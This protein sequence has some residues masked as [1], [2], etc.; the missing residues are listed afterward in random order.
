MAAPDRDKLHPN[1]P[2]RPAAHRARLRGRPFGL[3]DKNHLVPGPPTV[4]ALAPKAAQLSLHLAYPP[5][6]PAHCLPPP[7]EPRRNLAHHQ[8]QALDPF[9]QVGRLHELQGR[10]EQP[11]R[12]GYPG[13]GRGLGVPGDGCQDVQGRLS[14]KERLGRKLPEPFVPKPPGGRFHFGAGQPLSYGPGGDLELFGNLFRGEPFQGQ[15]K[16]PGLPGCKPPFR[17]VPQGSAFHRLT[18]LILV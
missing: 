15:L 17:R 5:R 4:G 13:L 6:K 2:R 3:P 18:P 7:A 12:G 11:P 8:L 16:G 10:L 9:G 1:D 14:L